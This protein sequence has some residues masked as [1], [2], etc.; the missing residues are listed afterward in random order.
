[1]NFPTSP[2]VNDTYSFGGATWIW[3]GNGWAQQAAL[4][5]GLPAQTGN[6]GKYLTTDG[7]NPS[8]ATVGG[9]GSPG[10][11]TTQI[12][13]N[14]GGVFGGATNLAYNNTGGFTEVGQ[15]TLTTNPTGTNT[16]LF[17]S[18]RTVIPTISAKRANAPEITLRPS[19]SN[20]WYGGDYVLNGNVNPIGN[21]FNSTSGF[22]NVG[23]SAAVTGINQNG[24]GFKN[25]AVYYSTTNNV[26]GTGRLSSSILRMCNTPSRRSAYHCASFAYV[27][28][29]SVTSRVF[30]GFVAVANPTSIAANTIFDFSNFDG[31]RVGFLYDA[32]YSNNLLFVYERL[33]F[34]KTVI[35]LG[36]NFVMFNAATGNTA[37][38]S[39]TPAFDVEFF[40][41]KAGTIWYRAYNWTNSQST[42][43]S[44]VDGGTGFNAIST[45]MSWYPQMIIAD[46]AATV[47]SRLFVSNGSSY[48]YQGPY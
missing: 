13:F 28:A 43:G 14:N 21:L 42:S 9:G 41:D 23:T 22:V 10:G 34:Q 29:S 37:P 35:D 4:V 33:S 6:S 18:A 38:S 7:T 26:A 27:G 48:C 31:N 39:T 45:A 11:S 25:C 1:M 30:S 12:Q 8:W 46:K 20:D 3:N 15:I 5:S 32:S 19:I 2:A 24:W 36:A 44:V 40:W 17:S 16:A 47:N